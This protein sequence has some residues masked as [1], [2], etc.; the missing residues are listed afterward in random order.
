[1]RFTEPFP[2]FVLNTHSSLPVDIKSQ[3]GQSWD[4][5]IIMLFNSKYKRQW[6]QFAIS[7]QDKTQ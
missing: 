7:Q 6:I 4:N 5:Y 3:K 1:M 2:S